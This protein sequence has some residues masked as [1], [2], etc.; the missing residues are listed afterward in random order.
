MTA[1][2]PALLVTRDDGLLDEVLRLAA[3]AGTTL[4]VAHDPTSALRGW[5]TASLVLVGADQAALVAEQRPPRREQVHVVGRTPLGDAVFKSALAVGAVDVVELPTADTWVVELLT[6][7]ADG[8]GTA[9]RTVGVT[10][11]SGGAGA[12]TFACALGLTAVAEGPTMLLDLDP[13]GPGIDRVVGL[14]GESGVRWDAL[15]D[16]HGRL[17]SR[18]LRAALP[19]RAGLGVLTWPVGPPVAVGP[20]SVREVLSAARRGHD[21]VVVDL[22]RALDEA[23][24]EVV[25]RCDHLLL[26]VEPSVAG[27]ASAGRVADVLRGVNDRLGVVV[28]D[29]GA[30]VGP[31]E[32]ATVL[33][34]PLV[35]VV[36]TQRR[37]LEHIDL[38]LGPVRSRRSPLAR[39]ATEV[40]QRLAGLRAAA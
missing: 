8:G 3:A 22:P 23:G 18:S 20:E 38:G 19:S 37:L 10:G 24:A 2:P 4:D 5:S 26:V 25:A 28:R 32:V 29:T 17:G 30:P 15:V 16:S 34:L 14:D 13:L 11:G 36:G 1:P 39:A 9:A 31:E 40:L 12:T 35:G 6:D 21:L 33:D 7:A 27:V